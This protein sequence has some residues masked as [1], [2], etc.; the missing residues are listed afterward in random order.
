[1][2]FGAHPFRTEQ[3][4]LVFSLAPVIPAYLIRRMADFPLRL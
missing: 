2:M 3:E 1:M 4:E